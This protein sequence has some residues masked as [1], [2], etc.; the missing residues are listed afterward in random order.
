MLLPPGKTKMNTK[1]QGGVHM[2]IATL[3]LILTKLF[4]ASSVSNARRAQI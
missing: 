1:M 2:R 4:L 3:T